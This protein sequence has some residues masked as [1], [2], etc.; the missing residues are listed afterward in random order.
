MAVSPR[1]SHVEC[2]TFFFLT[3]QQVLKSVPLHPWTSKIALSISSDR[4]HIIS[5]VVHFTVRQF[6]RIASSQ[7]WKKLCLLVLMLQA[8]LACS[9]PHI[10]PHWPPVMFM[11]V[12]P[13]VRCQDYLTLSVAFDP[14]G[15]LDFWTSLSVFHSFYATFSRTFAHV[16]GHCCSVSFANVSTSLPKE[17]NNNNFQKFFVPDKIYT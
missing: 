10:L 4:K 9:H 11:T 14:V 12:N 15:I 5:Y 13:M 1:S 3:S 2:R 8:T 16:S 6:G 7:Y 17:K